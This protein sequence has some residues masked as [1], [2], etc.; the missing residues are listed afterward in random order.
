MVDSDD[1]ECQLIREPRWPSL[2]DHRL[3][4]FLRHWA[5]SRRG[6][7]VP[8]RSS[9]DPAQI[10]PCLPFVWMYRYDP[11]TGDF[12]CTLAG[13]EINTAWGGSIIGMRLQDFMP[14]GMALSLR[15]HYRSVLT[16]PALLHSGL[17]IVPELAVTKLARRLVAPLTRDDGTPFGVFGISVYVYDRARQMDAPVGPM[18]DAVLYDCTVLPPVPP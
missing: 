5:E 6:A 10:G 18:G 14:A 11:V 17:R 9:I 16:I 1:I 8:T 15:V 3:A 4:L 13:D 12:T 2:D 7:A